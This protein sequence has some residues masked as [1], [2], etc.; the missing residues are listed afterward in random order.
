MQ[1]FIKEEGILRKGVLIREEGSIAKKRINKQNN[2]TMALF[3]LK[4]SYGKNKNYL[5]IMLSRE[6]GHCD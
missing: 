5:G 6:W 3:I 2:E 4:I 1:Y